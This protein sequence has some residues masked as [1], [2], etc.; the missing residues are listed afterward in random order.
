MFASA[1]S[2][3]FAAFSGVASFD[4]LTPPTSWSR[5][6]FHF[7]REERLNSCSKRLAPV[8]QKED[9]AIHCINHYAVDNAIGLRTT[10]PLD[11]DLSGG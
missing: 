9:S 1:H 2:G 10:Y 6:A 3:P 8:V 4:T 5:S 11:S 7:H